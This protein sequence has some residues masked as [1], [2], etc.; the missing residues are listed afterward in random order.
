MKDATEKITK[1]YHVSDV[2]IGFLNE[3]YRETECEID[4]EFEISLTLEDWKCRDKINEAVLVALN[5]EVSLNVKIINF[6]LLH[7]DEN[8]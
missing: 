3:T 6:V 4:Q 8:V 1:K 7:E 5:N 2:T